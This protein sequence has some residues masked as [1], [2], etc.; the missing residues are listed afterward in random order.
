[1]LCLLTDLR[2]LHRHWVGRFFGCHVPPP[3]SSRAPSSFLNEGSDAADIGPSIL[4]THSPHL[5]PVVPSPCP[6]QARLPP[7]SLHSTSG[8]VGDHHAAALHGDDVAAI[9]QP[10][11][12]K[13]ESGQVVGSD[14]AE[15]GQCV[16]RGEQ[17]G[18]GRGR[19]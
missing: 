7:L 12:L 16:T 2:H 14:G 8:C 4:T 19:G 3:P 11:H 1:M 15:E 18:R 13:G 17:Q 5:Q 9:G 10:G 6:L